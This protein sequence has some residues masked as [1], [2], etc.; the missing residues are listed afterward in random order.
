MESEH[1][2]VGLEETGREEQMG[3]RV[4]PGQLLEAPGC[5]DKTP[6]T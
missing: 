4:P 3:Q 5:L 2:A 1:L 6:G